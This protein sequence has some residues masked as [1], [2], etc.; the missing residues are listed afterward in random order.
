[1]HY[2]STQEHA[3]LLYDDGKEA[4]T[5]DK[6]ADILLFTPYHALTENKP[7]T[8]TLKQKNGARMPSDH[9]G[10]LTEWKC[11]NPHLLLTLENPSKHASIYTRL[12]K[13]TVN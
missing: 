6:E 3:Q 1:M 4:K 11:K 7:L 2:F 10:L 8:C 9:V 13:A 12:T 5:K